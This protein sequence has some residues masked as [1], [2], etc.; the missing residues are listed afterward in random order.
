MRVESR[1]TWR[2][3]EAVSIEISFGP[4]A[5]EVV[6]PASVRDAQDDHV[7]FSIS[8]TQRKRTAY[9]QQVLAGLRAAS[10]RR[11]RRIDVDLE[12]R[13]TWKGSRYA[14]RARDLSRGGAFIESR[15]LPTVGAKVDVEL[16]LPDS[17]P[18]L[19]L[20]AEVTWLRKRTGAP[21]FGVSFK[22]PD[23]T[24]AARLHDAVRECEIAFSS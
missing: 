22:L 18:T 15:V 13:W 7:T 8:V 14:S 19:A 12:V 10:A 1:E 16:R 4:M 9:V 23:R 5:D 24:V 2:V 20:D 3:G 6:I 11:H 17:T 21:G